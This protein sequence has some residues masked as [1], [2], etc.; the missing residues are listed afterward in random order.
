MDFIV[1]EDKGQQAGK[2]EAKHLWFAEHQIELIQAPLP[3]GDY[4]LSNEKVADVINR[5]EKRGIPVKKMDF[6]GTYKVCVDTKKDMQEIASNICG[7][8]HE[9]FR[10]ECLLAQNNEITLYVLI[11][12][13]ENVRSIEDVMN[14]KNPRLVRH[15]KILKMHQIGKWKH[16][17]VSKIPPTSGEILAKAMKTMEEKYDV[18]FLFC[19]PTDAAEQIFS[20]LTKESGGI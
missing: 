10:D 9:R 6:I 19:N 17:K 4:I 1:I 11:E 15:E 7:K 2:H 13:E 8:Q 5:K 20:L 3:V 16:I 14:W 18:K 12:N